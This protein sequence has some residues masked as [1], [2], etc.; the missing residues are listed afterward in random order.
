[1]KI[2]LS[3]ALAPVRWWLFMLGVGVV[4]HEWIPELRTIGFW[5][6]AVVVELLG[7][8]FSLGGRDTS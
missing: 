6:S 1:M 2:L 7:A 4:H 8:A 3:V 5:W